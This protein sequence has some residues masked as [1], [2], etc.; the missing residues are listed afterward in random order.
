MHHFLLANQVLWQVKNQSRG[1]K[2]AIKYVD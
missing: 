1:G 2:E